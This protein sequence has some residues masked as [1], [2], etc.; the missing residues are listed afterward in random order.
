M[1]LADFTPS[2]DLPEIDPGFA[3]M[4]VE[5][6]NSPKKRMPV[7]QLF[8]EFWRFCPAKV[9]EDYRRMVTEMPGFQE[10]YA[11]R[12]FAPT[13]EL[14]EL[15]AM[16]TGSFGHTFGLFIRNNGLEPK[17]ALNYHDRHAR[18]KESGKLDGMPAELQYAVLRGFQLHDLMHVMTG[19]AAKSTGEL[20]VQAFC[21]SQWN[22]PY[23]AMWM[24]VTA[25]RMTF[26][27]PTMID[28][29]MSAISD[30]WMAGQKAQ[31]IQFARLEDHFE[32]P[33]VA[34]RRRF[35]IETAETGT[36]LA[37]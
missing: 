11:E 35:G 3:E 18:M 27:D 30:G 36:E 24:S 6:F 16:P 34:L 29:Y 22:F 37:A 5:C 32:E 10:S 25:T 31:N 4:L 23:F 21:L 13:H 12:H 28:P 26:L 20:G 14:D 2:D 33:L 8:N 9:A 19:Y 7:H 17:L 15:L 1:A